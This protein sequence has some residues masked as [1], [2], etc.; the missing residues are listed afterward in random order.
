MEWWQIF[1]VLFLIF[2]AL[3]FY[4]AMAKETDRKQR[5]EKLSLMAA[6]EPYEDGQWRHPGE[7]VEGGKERNLRNTG[8]DE[9]DPT[10]SF[11]TRLPKA[12][13]STINRK[14]D[15]LGLK[16]KVEIGELQVKHITNANH[17]ADQFF[18]LQNKSK[19]NK[20]KDLETEKKILENEYALKDV[21]TID[22]LRQLQNEDKK[23]DFDIS[24]AEKKARLSGINN[25]PEPEK[26]L[27]PKEQRA[28]ELAE[29]EE[30]I[31]QLEDQMKKLKDNDQ[32][33]AD[34]KQI[35]LNQIQNKLF[36]LYEQRVDLL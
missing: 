35:Q 22:S 26:Q 2:V 32:I 29:V 16:D 10:E 36:E 20:A 23:L 11:V 31:R 5:Q 19:T 1:G 34:A 18:D 6:T 13:N 4:S 33:P 12:V 9:E 3:Y 17:Y 7:L 14:L 30:K 21:E 25:Q 8:G 27:T 24:I 28:Q 15:K